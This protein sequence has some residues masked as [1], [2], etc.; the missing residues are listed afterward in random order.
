MEFR[1][2]LEARPPSGRDRLDIVRGAVDA[3]LHPAERTLPWWLA[4]SWAVTSL[5]A[6]GV[7]LGGL[8]DTFGPISAL[9]WGVP[10][11]LFWVLAGAVLVARGIPARSTVLDASG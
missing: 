1:G 6:L 11:G 9:V 4:T 7:S 10:F 5:L 3:R 2:I 8:G